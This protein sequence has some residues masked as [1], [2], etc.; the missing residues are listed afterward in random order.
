MLPE[1]ASMSAPLGAHAKRGGAA[2]RLALIALGCAVAA[3]MMLAAREW[4]EMLHQ[5]WNIDTYNHLLLLPV[6]MGWLVM[7]KAEELAQISP[8]PFSPGLLLVIVALGLWSAGRTSGIN[9]VAHAGAVGMVQGAIVAML[10]MRA[11]LLLALPLAMGVFLVPFGDEIIAPLQTITA[12]IAIALTLW[13]GVPASIEGIHIDT[14]AGLFIVAE[15]CSGV[16]FL[17]AMVQLGVLVC[18]TR[19]AS[20]RRRTAFMAACIIV[21]ILA[22]G[23]RAWATIYVAQF[24]GA[25][26][27]TG[28]DHIVYGWVF[29]AII[30]AALLGGAWRLFEREPE[31]HGWRAADLSHQLWIARTEAIPLAPGI[32]ACAIIA[33]AAIGAFG[34]VR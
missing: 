20:W 17:I 1:P 10:G 32:A 26:R 12:E 7:L 31:E 8:H 2:W 15:A 33:L 5:W 9:L 4:V 25:E 18:C 14:P 34:P 27:A 21:P 6:I 30:V 23:M 11:A 28:F 22:N 24:I 19:F 3:L 13:S 29:F 16:T